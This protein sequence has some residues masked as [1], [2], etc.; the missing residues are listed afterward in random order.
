MESHR[1]SKL[2]QAKLVATC[3]SQGKQTYLQFDRENFKKKVVSSFPAA[4]IQLHK[5]HHPTIKSLFVAIRKP[6]PSET[7]ARASVAPLAS[8]KEEN[9]RELPRY[10]KYF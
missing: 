5:L 10:K 3:S 1:K 7:A 8:Q 4:N 9:I 6:L 2:Y